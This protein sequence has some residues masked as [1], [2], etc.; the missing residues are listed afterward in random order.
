MKWYAGSDHAGYALKKQLI[1]TLAHGQRVLKGGCE[2]L[3]SPRPLGPLTDI[4]AP[5]F[6]AS[7]LH[8][9]Q[10]E[11]VTL[12]RTILDPDLQGRLRDLGEPDRTGVSRRVHQHT[13]LLNQIP[14]NFTAIDSDR[15][16]G[17]PPTLHANSGNTCAIGIRS[18]A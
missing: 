10:L 7:R 13:M 2:D 18:P 1:A 8:N 3:F 5:E 16:D 4:A 15:A 14:K 12:V 17:V 9:G 6:E 11:F